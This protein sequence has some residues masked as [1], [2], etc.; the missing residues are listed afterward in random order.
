MTVLE[1]AQVGAMVL[2]AIRSGRLHVFTHPETRQMV[3][4]RGAALAAAFW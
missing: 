3:T 4:G 2:D 1:P